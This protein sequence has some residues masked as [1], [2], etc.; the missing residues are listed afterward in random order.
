LIV[1]CDLVLILSSHYKV[2][3]ATNRPDALVLKCLNGEV[4]A[5]NNDDCGV[6]VVGEESWRIY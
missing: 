5:K 6:N 3:Q 4:Q 1:A 2:I